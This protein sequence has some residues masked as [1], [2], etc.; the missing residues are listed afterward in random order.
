[1]SDNKNIVQ[2]FKSRKPTLTA[3]PLGGS[4]LAR[5]NPGLELLCIPATNYKPTRKIQNLWPIVKLIYD[6]NDNEITPQ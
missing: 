4:A 5:F 1:M 2:N 6:V 3:R